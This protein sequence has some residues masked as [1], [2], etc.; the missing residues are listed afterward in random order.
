M[1]SRRVLIV[2]DEP[3]IVELLSFIL[4]VEGFEVAAATDGE[5]AMQTLQRDRPDVVVLDL[6][7]PRK[8]GF[9]VLK[10]IKADPQLKSIPI[11][12]LTAKGQ[13]Q[14]RRLAEEMGVDSFMTKPF[15]NRDVIDE[16]RRLANR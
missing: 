15:A 1:A 16:I 7:L 11:I 13:A 9:E 12:V 10:Q 2:E 5:A 14:D 6:M 4:D 8:N 3:H